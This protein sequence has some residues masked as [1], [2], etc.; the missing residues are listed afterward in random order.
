MSLWRTILIKLR[1]HKPKPA[2]SQQEAL[3]VRPLRNPSLQW[4]HNEEGN[5]VIALPRRRDWK[6]RLLASFFAVPESRPVV[7]DEVGSFVWQRCDGN[8]S[9]NE[10][11]GS[12]CQEYKLNAKEVRVSLIEYMRMLAK[13]GMIAVA[14]PE[15][16]ID[17]LDEATRKELKI[18]QAPSSPPPTRQNGDSPQPTEDQ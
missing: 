12:L 9:V 8:H 10:L 7:L 13:R 2:L 17:K 5:V 15:E 18:H 1:L 16:L 3:E 14:V 11:V 6:G 4:E